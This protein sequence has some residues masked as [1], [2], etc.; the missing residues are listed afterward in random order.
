MAFTP[1]PVL[2]DLDKLKAILMV[3][4]LKTKDNAL[5]QVINNLIDAVKQS[6]GVTNNTINNTSTGLVSKTYLTV[7]DET[8]SL[9][10]SRQELMGNFITFDDSVPGERTI[11]SPEWSVLTNGDVIN[12]EL[13]Y[14]AGDVIM[15]HVP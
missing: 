8:A 5:F 3:S 15:T 13:I 6:Q 12:P 4:G 14:G 10:N 9:P 1:P 7:D 11:S 2:P